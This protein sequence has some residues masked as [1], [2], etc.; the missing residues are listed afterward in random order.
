MLVP[1]SGASVSRTGALAALVRGRVENALLGGVPGG[2]RLISL[3]AGPRELTIFVSLP[4]PG[5]H[6]NVRRYP[7]AVVGGG[8]RGLLVSSS[9][10]IPGLVSIADVAPSVR[11]LERGRTPVLRSRRERAAPASL[12]R[13]D[14]RLS[15]AH[16]SRLP[17]TFV[18]AGFLL[19][20]CALALVFRSRLFG[21]AALLTAPVALASALVLSAL[22]VSRPAT[23]TA[24]LAVLTAAGS[25]GTAAL[26]ASRYRLALGLAGVLVLYLVVLAVWPV[27]NSLA[28]I[29]PHPDGGGRFYGVTNQLQTLL[30][31]PALVSAALLGLRWLLPIAAL[32]L[33]TVGAARTGADGGGALVLA[34]GFIVL[35]LRLRGTVLTAARAALL[36]AGAV[37]ASL[38]LVGIDAALGGSSHVTRTLGDGPVAVAEALAHRVHVSVLGAVSSWRAWST[39]AVSLA[40]LAWFAIRRPRFPVGDALLAALAVSLLVNDTPRDVAAFGALACAALWSWER[41]RLTAA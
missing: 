7:I 11:A 17:A 20:N 30:I 3:D 1:G 29:G 2:R 6:H 36:V 14:R 18:L 24:A 22:D 10:R 37:A 23:V 34:V 12:D 21:R 13:L 33:V 40:A 31:T 28:A 5:K 8:Y 38:V 39:T 35:A 4:P 41:V 16:D 27:V 15:Q 26:L 9:T 19:L 32:A 25:V